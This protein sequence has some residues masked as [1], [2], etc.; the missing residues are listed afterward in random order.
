MHTACFSSSRG[1]CVQGVCP[2][3]WGLH[4]C[5]QTPPDADPQDIEL[6]D[7]EPVDL[8]LDADHVTCDACWDTN[9]LWTDKHL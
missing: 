1:V 9:P 4:P 5:R 6:L 2:I 8:P 3:S 7:A